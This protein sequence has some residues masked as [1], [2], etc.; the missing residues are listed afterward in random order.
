[1]GF[2]FVNWYPHWY[3]GFRR[4]IR[5]EHG[6][7]AGVYDWCWHIGFWEVRCIRKRILLEKRKEAK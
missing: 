2:Q 7:T 6:I 1:M 4:F 5:A 3:V